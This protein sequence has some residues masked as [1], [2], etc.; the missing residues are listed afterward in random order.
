M[1]LQSNLLLGAHMSIA[2]GTDK[3]VARGEALGCT[4]IQIFTRNATRWNA[5]ELGAEEIRVFKNERARSGIMVVAHDSYLINLAT[6]DRRLLNKSINSFRDEMERAELLEIPFLIMHPG[7]HTGSGEDIGLRSIGSALN[8]LLKET[9][10]F[11]VS[12]L[13]E[14]TAGQGTALGYSFEQLARIIDQV[15]SPERVGVCL[16][17]CHAF[18]AGYDLRD[19]DGCAGVFGKLNLVVG[20]DRLKALHLNDAKKGLGS[21]VDRH[22][23]I[24]RGMLGLECFRFIMTDSRFLTVPKLIE[25][26]KQLDG[27]DMDPVNLGLLRELAGEAPDGFH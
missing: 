20:L 27:M 25:T 19:A 24:G 4:V 15:S 26:P 7:S 3:A 9:S 5:P 14:N 10:G 13:L 12:I 22:E 11:R 16:D 23:H 6:P 21:R 1:V 18:A 17:T 2:R 8:R